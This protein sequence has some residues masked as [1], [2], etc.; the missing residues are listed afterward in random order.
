MSET[1]AEFLQRMQETGFSDSYRSQ[2]ERLADWQLRLMFAPYPI[3][4]AYRLWLYRNRTANRDGSL[5][6]FLNVWTK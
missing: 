4:R 3:G 1:T 6:K 2:Q 5:T